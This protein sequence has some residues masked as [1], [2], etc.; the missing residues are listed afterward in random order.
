MCLLYKG[1]PLLSTI[2]KNHPRMR[3]MFRDAG[4][5]SRFI[6]FQ[7]AYLLL[8]SAAYF[9]IPKKY[10]AFHLDFL[11]SYEFIVSRMHGSP[12]PMSQISFP[13]N[14]GSISFDWYSN[15]I[16]RALLSCQYSV[17]LFKDCKYL[18]CSP[19]KMFSGCILSLSTPHKWTS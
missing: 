9:L 15:V 13:S 19:F 2:T 17:V 4:G 7:D 14:E 3:Y 10:Q 1:I 11:E 18:Y 5:G 6:S 8:S 16:G 12:C